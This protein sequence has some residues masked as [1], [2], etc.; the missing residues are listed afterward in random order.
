MI[1]TTLKRITDAAKTRNRRAF[2]QERADRP[3]LADRGWIAAER[4]E[5][6]R[7]RLILE[8][9]RAEQRKAVA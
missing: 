9:D 4:F 3:D 5:R 7:W 2:A 6:V 1:V 8:L